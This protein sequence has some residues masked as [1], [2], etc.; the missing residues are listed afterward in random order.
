MIAQ[1]PDMEKV[2]HYRPLAE[3][4]PGHWQTDGIETEDGIRLHYT[5]TGGNKSPLLLLHGIQVNGLSWLRVAQALEADYDVIMPD[6]R[7]HGKTGHGDQPMTA[8]R[9]VQDIITLIETLELEMP[10]VIGHSMGADIAGRLAAAYPLWAVMLVDPA[11]VNFAAAMLPAD[12]PPPWM[13]AIVETM[14]SLK[15]L[16]HAERMLTG[17]R[18]LPPGMPAMEEADYVPF[19]EGQSEFD[20]SVFGALT[21]LGYLFEEP[22]TIAQINCPVLLLTAQSMTPGADMSV[23]LAAFKDN[24]DKGQHIHFE[25]SGHFIQYDQFDR[26]IEVVRTF[27][28]A[29]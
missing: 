2:Q 4:V 21:R 17:L 18:L 29:Q 11:L 1:H 10:L 27:F 15:T 9:M 12:E 28:N 24:L 13:Q 8:Q 22:E 3:L 26:F 20:P 6:L 7:G 25:D 14:R 19:I 23:G 16:P 5:R